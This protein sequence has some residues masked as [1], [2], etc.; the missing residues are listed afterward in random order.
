MKLE[1]QEYEARKLVNVHKHTDGPW[2]W[3][4]YSAHPYIGCRSGCEFC[5]CRGG[6]YLGK[7]GIDTFDTHIRVKTNAVALLDKELAKL[8]PDVIGCGDWQQPAE[9]RYQLSR[10]MLEVVLTH[11]FPLFIVE[12]SP[13][14]TRDIDLL[15]EIDK[16]TQVSVALSISNLNPALKQTFEP[17]SP[18]VLRRFQAMS[19]LAEAGILV[20][21]SLMPIIPLFGDDTHTLEEVIVATKG[22]GGSFVLGG[23]LSMSGVQAERT[24]AAAVELDDSLEAQWR[25]MYHWQPGGKPAYSPPRAYTSRLGLLVRQLCTKHGLADRMPRYIPPGPLGINKRVAEK[26]FLKTYDLELEGAQS[27]RIWAYRKAAWT[28]DEMQDSIS[29]L[30]HSEGA[31]GLRQLPNIG[32]RLAT[33][34]GDWIE[35]A[36]A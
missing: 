24:L 34:I 15:V 10:Q 28:V 1:F 7:D 25:D 26:L 13:L 2:F 16:R 17:R 27:Y 3:D 5:Y 36:D 12:R 8:E 32:E 6:R 9:D 14:L 11:E 19:E 31:A 35:E 22:H 23:G 18:G 4:K 29:E 30:Y 21:T 20:G 33:H